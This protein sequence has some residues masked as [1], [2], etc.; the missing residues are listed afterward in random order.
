VKI[1]HLSILLQKKLLQE[2]I[3]MIVAKMTV[4]QK[5]K[6]TTVAVVNAIIQN[7]LVRLLVAVVQLLSMS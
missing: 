2:W 4:I 7:V 6:T 5:I 1:I 3:M